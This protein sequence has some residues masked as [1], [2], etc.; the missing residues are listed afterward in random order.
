MLISTAMHVHHCGGNDRL[1]DQPDVIPEPPA[2]RLHPRTP[3]RL[4]PRE[5]PICVHDPVR[6]PVAAQHTTNRRDQVAHRG[7]DVRQESS[8]LEVLKRTL[9]PFCTQHILHIFG[10]QKIYA[11]LQIV[12]CDGKKVLEREVAVTRKQ[13]IQE[14]HLG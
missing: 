1:A 12:L 2:H 10:P 4:R 14:L 5:A 11:V 7:V 13:K 9:Q 6:R 8:F 3:G